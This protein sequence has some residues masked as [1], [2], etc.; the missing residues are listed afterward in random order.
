MFTIYKATNKIN[1]NSYIGFD[2]NWPYRKSAHKCAVKRGSNLV[3]YNAIRKYGWENFEWEILEQSDDKSYL[4][5]E[6]EEFYI[7]KYNTHYIEGTGYNM[8]F[9]G[10]ATFGWVPSEKT[11]QKISESKKG[12]PSW[13][14]GKPSPWVGEKNKKG[15]GK[16][17]PKLCKKYLVTDPEGNAY[18]ILGL[19]YFCIEHNLSASNLT[20]TG[21]YKGWQCKQ[22]S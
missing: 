12:K 3:F 7:R 22:I 6:R 1:G 9:G 19:K 10:E 4:L 5:R 15:K 20:Y 2:C 13:N 17:Q 14:K 11:K 8:T 16:K 21:K 18:E